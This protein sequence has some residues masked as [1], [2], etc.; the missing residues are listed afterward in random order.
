MKNLTDFDLLNSI[1]SFKK[2]SPYMFMIY[3]VHF[4]INYFNLL[5]KNFKEKTQTNKPTK[6][7]SIP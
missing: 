1:F 4:T 7:N 3:I 5:E 2:I 6:N